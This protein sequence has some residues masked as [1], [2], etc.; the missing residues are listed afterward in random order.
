V[1]SFISSYQTLGP[2][3]GWKLRQTALPYPLSHPR[4]RCYYLGRNAVYHGARALG[5]RSGD[6]VVFPAWHSGTESAPLMHLGCQL[7]FYEVRRDLTIDLDEVESLITPATRAIYAIHFIGFQAPIQELREMADRHGVALIE[8]VALGFLGAVDGRPLGTWGDISIFCL[9]KS[10]PTAAGGVLAVNRPDIALPAEVARGTTYSE[11]NLTV[12]RFL[13][14]VEMHGGWPGLWLRRSVQFFGRG[15][16]KAAGLRVRSPDALDFE[17]ELLDH[18]MGTITRAIARVVD[19]PS[20]AW[21]RRANYQWLAREL[22]GSGVH[23]LRPTL[24]EG[25]VP[26]FFPVWA[27][28][29]FP[30]IARLQAEGVDAVPVW[31][32]HHAYLPTGRFLETEFLTRHAIEVPVHQTLA[33]KHLRRIRDSLLRHATWSDFPEAVEVALPIEAVSI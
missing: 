6:E 23:L 18:R 31:G 15:G 22:A 33:V 7:S 25:A 29:K 3:S 17:P 10:L 32:T 11:L 16:V 19:Y 21:R 28:D 24:P 14:H 30:T 4:K 1:P 27:K 20:V 12:K 13:E 9:Y 2:S 8:D 26:L 5:L